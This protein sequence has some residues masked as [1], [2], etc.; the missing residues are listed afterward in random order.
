MSE[1]EA[2]AEMI[3]RARR[4][5]RA[6]TVPERQL[7]GALRG[8]RV[9]GEKFR[10]QVPIGRYIVDFIHLDSR[11]I[12]EIDGRSHDDRYE[13]DLARQSW[14][15]GQGFR[16]LRFANDDVLDDVEAVVDA[17]LAAIPL[18]RADFD[19]AGGVN[20][21]AHGGILDAAPSP[22]AR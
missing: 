8:R 14:L 6:M 1:R 15:E 18:S 7:W 5:R 16:M 20:R 17:I 10:R 13:Q 9:N 22:P 2:E 11:I 3:R 21:L 12:I 19:A 4:L